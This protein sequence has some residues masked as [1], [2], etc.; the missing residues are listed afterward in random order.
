M[1]VHLGR[2]DEALD[3][4]KRAA[5]HVYNVDSDETI[6]KAVAAGLLNNTAAAYMALGDATRAA[7]LLHSP[8]QG[9]GPGPGL[10]SPVGGYRLTGSKPV[11]KAHMVSALGTVIS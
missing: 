9:A 5:E 11:L 3:L 8:A 2:P 1:V 4:L 7:H 10:D 6:Q